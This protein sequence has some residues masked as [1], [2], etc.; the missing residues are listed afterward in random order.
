MRNL[1]ISALCFSILFVSGCS[2]K[3]Q[4][5]VDAQLN[6][7]CAV[8]GGIKVYETV[9]LPPEIPLGRVITKTT[10]INTYKKRSGGG[11]YIE[12]DP[13]THTSEVLNPDLFDP[14]F[15]TNALGPDYIWKNQSRALP[16]KE[17]EGI[18]VYRIHYKLTSHA[19]KKLLGEMVT[20]LRLGNGVWSQTQYSCPVEG[21]SLSLLSG[22]PLVPAVFQDNPENSTGEKKNKK[23]KR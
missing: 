3:A 18:S 2:T 15:G 14:A 17:S 7:L 13:V 11:Y 23:S 8:D 5:A 16:E 9:T 22:M 20:Y 10:Y 19:N 12:R 1:V 21:D 6:Q 4:R